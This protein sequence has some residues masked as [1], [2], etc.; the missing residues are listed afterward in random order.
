MMNTRHRPW[1]GGGFVVD[2]PRQ[3]AYNKND[4]LRRLM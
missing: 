3:K 1:D 4:V 2:K